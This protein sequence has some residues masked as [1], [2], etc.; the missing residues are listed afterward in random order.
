MPASNAASSAPVG[1]RPPSV[2]GD[3]ELLDRIGQG[4]MGTVFRARQRSMDR[5]VAVKLLLPRLAGD[6]AYVERFFRE[7]RAAARLNHPNI[8]LALT[9]GED[10][11][12]Y[13]FAM[14]YVEGHTVSLLLKAGP[15]EERRALE[16][17]LQI[18]RA[19]DYAWSRERIVH[20]DI[21]PGNILIT[22]DGTAKLADLGLAHEASAETEGALE[23]EGKILGTPC[24]MAPEQILRKPDLDVRCDLYA[25]GA[26]LF[27]MA[28][29]RTPF[30]GGS[31]KAILARQ[32]REPA[33]DPRDLRPGLS[34]NTAYILEKLLAKDRDERY[35][36][37]QALAAD[38]E[39][40]LRGDSLRPRHA[41]HIR[42]APRSS[43]LSSAIAVLAVLLAL[44]GIAIA[45]LADR[46]RGDG[47]GQGKGPKKPDPPPTP[48]PIET[49][50]AAAKRAWDDAVAYADAHPADPAGA[51]ERLRAIERQFPDTPFRERAAVRRLLL[52][53][54]LDKKVQK[55]IS[56]LTERADALVRETRY[57][58]AFALFAKPPAELAAGPWPARLA[59]AKAAIER[60]AAEAFRAALARADALAERGELDDALRA[61]EAAGA[62]LPDPWRDELAARVAAVQRRQQD[63]ADKARAAREV[64]H[65]RLLADALD[66][67]RARKYAEAVELLKA[68]LAEAPPE[69]R[70]ELEA[71][72]AE[73]ASL[74]DFWTRAEL[75]AQQAIGK[76]FSIR[77]IQGELVSIENG[78]LTIQ[79]RG[80]RFSEEMKNLAT[81]QLLAFG[82]SGYTSLAAPPAAARFLLAE[83]K[84][85]AAEARL[86]AAGA[87][88][89]A[90]RA[91]L[92]RFAAATLVATAT[93]ELDAARKLLAAGDSEPAAT[94]LRAFLR[95]YA[96][97][98]P[99]A[100]LCADA[101]ALLAQATAPRP[102]RWGYVGGRAVE[103]PAARVRNTRDDALYLTERYA[104]S[105]YRIGLLN[106]AY[107]VRLHFAETAPGIT[108]PG[109]RVFSVA[110]E[111]KPALT[112]FDLLKETGSRPFVALNMEFDIQV[113]DGE[114]TIEFTPKVQSPMIN[115]IEVAPKDPAKG[116]EPLLINCGG[117]DYTA[118]DGRIWKKD[119]EYPAH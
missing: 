107:T 50:L 4:A 60:K 71:E 73:A 32:L 25:L 20:R 54:E 1:A 57:A 72:L 28:T 13:Y 88:A 47:G 81:D 8:V 22:P 6:A 112:N 66:L 5:P 59:A 62:S 110:I 117:P 119:Q 103:R 16:I 29:G 77:G 39:R 15:L 37:A 86:K 46:M 31:T 7:A 61:Y 97:Q 108:A 101:K 69:H 48:S 75:G 98:P 12:F 94:A 14:E 51:I 100:T 11:G 78:R 93:K 118:Q 23:A 2:V 10:Q 92:Q 116:T 70:T 42:R 41:P 113:S 21:K 115:A 9:V 38:I 90:I 53:G 104:L 67:Y 58:E 52:E 76:P 36:D 35:P 105:A 85:D 64:A 43:G 18:A 24:Y 27:H 33:P 95:R 84:P 114:L 91:R 83:G 34:D 82:L 55:A 49:H 74:Q 30:E 63:L 89:A 26:T 79:S 19:L 40:A 109:Q 96:D 56:D 102:G 17:T 45:I 111:G 44:I 3:F 68:R 87:G 80:G 106:G 65:L 99:V